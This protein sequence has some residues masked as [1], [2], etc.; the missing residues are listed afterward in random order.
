MNKK[1]YTAIFAAL[2][3]AGAT[4]CSDF[5][6]KAP[7]LSLTETD[8]YS[9]QER[10][11]G[12]IR[13]V[14]TRFKSSFMASKAYVCV[15]N[16][17]DD[18][19]NVSGNGIEALYSY[20]MSVGQDTQDNYQTWNGAYGVI[21]SANT[22]LA[23][24]E[25][26]KEVAGDNYDRY[27]AEMKFCRALSYYY[28][29][30]L[31]SQPYKLNPSA[32]SVPLRLQAE[33]S[34]ANNDLE[35][36]TN[37]QVYAQ[38]L[39]DT[40]DYTDLPQASATYEAITRATQGAALMLRMRVY[41]EME[42]WAE[43]IRCGEAI[44]GYSLAASVTDPFQSSSSCAESI[45]SFPAATTNNGGGEQV[46]V[47]YF[48]YSGNSLIVDATSGIHSALYPNYNL[49]ADHRISDLQT[50]TEEKRILTKFTDGNEYLDWVPIFRYAETLL[51]LAECYANTGDEAKAIAALKQV[52][53]RALDAS[54]DPLNLD[55]L[56][57][58]ALKQAIYLEK[59]SEFIGEAIRAID[60]HRRGENYVKRLGTSD[61]FTTTPTT[62]G[63]VWPIPTVERANNNAIVD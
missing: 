52:R 28:L 37:A 47:P 36:S 23:N 41:M 49:A 15:E 27:V 21:N 16:I 7:E 3:G 43:A 53:R 31:Y 50:G 57:G 51:D 1:I 30:F 12:A 17:G 5:L 32:L 13:G 59:R 44:T 34:L 20:E 29:N 39:A 25:A 48:Y 45:F 9:S 35:R 33:N 22:A 60:I 26:N 55:T 19:I 4:S 11:E 63:Y 56:T 54:A 61:E 62:N 38:I 24:L 14:Y 18:M 6:D 58:D 46:S 2:L 8:I 10:M 42:N 40:E